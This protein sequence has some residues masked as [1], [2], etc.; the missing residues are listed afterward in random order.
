M[1]TVLMSECCV[2]SD[3]RSTTPHSRIKLPKQNIPINGAADGNS[4]ATSNSN[5]NGNMIRSSFDTSR[6]CSITISRSA[7]V[8]S[9]RMMGGWI[10]GTRA[11][12]EYAATAIAPSRCGASLPAT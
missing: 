5:T 9:A 4:N 1:V 11:M 10:R 3:R 8:V 2:V 7:R 6:S 12:Y